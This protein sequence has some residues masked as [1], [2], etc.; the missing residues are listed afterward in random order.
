MTEDFRQCDDRDNDQ[1]GGGDT[2]G[3]GDSWRGVC[4]FAV[5][6]AGRE[7]RGTVKGEAAGDE[8]DRLAAAAA[9]ALGLRRAAISAVVQRRLGSQSSAWR[10]ISRNGWESSSG[11]TG[12]DFASGGK[13]GTRC[14]RASTRVTPSDQTS[15][16]GESPEVAAS[17]ALYGLGRAIGARGSAIEERVSLESFNWSAEARML[18][19]LR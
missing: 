5:G 2:F 14:M 1:D 19:G 8:T 18:E 10:A 11:T 3:A 12:S 15:L 16:A 9:M 13:T 6:T 7:E 4:S 17:G